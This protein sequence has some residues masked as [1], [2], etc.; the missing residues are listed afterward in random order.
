M[1]FKEKYRFSGRSRRGGRN[2][3]LG[4]TLSVRTRVKAR[5][6]GAPSRA[7]MLLLLPATAVAA[8]LLVWL[9]VRFAGGLLFSRNPAF[10]LSR[11]IIRGDSP[12]TEDYIRGKQGIREGVNLFLFNIRSI[13][14]EFLRGAPNFKRMDIVRILPDTLSIEVTERTAVARIGR[15]GGFVVDGD[16]FVFGPRARQASLPVIVGY[17]GPLLRPGDRIKGNAG[18]AVRILGFCDGSPLGADLLISGI[19]VSGNFTGLADDMQIYL[20]SK[21]VVDFWWPRHG[22][23][24]QSPD[25][26]MED[27]L[28]VLRGVMRRAA[29]DG[30]R[31]RT[32][33]LALENYRENCPV[34]FWD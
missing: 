18:D 28:R 23:K 15:E 11:L 24:G 13:R 10:T 12:V 4:P 16:G 33:N 5:K 7:A 3:R 29:K 34:V 26:Q 8:G 21:T 22:S 32:V 20:A 27:R 9:G 2:R 6:R 31:P 14:E 25:R 30:K 19:D 1:W 17:R